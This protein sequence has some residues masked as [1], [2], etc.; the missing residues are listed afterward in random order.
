MKIKN[1]LFVLLVLLISSSCYNYKYIPQVNKYNDSVNGSFIFV[2]LKNSESYKGELIATDTN[3]VYVFD[4]K[5]EMC[6]R[7]NK[8]KIDTYTVRIARS[9]NS[10]LIGGVLVPFSFLHGFGLIISLP[11]NLATYLSLKLTSRS[12]FQYKPNEL[13]M[14]ELDTYARFPQGFPNG[15]TFK[16]IK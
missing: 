15:I 6:Y 7:F 1:Y 9:F 4:K 2:K 5:E 8:E 14:S 16:D 12:I 10:S 13:P 3:F 11:I